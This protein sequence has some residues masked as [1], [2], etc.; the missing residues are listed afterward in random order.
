MSVLV[1][2]LDSDFHADAVVA[3][4]NEHGVPVVRI[5]PTETD[6]VPT[7]V[8]IECEEQPSRAWFRS[9]DG[10]LIDLAAITGVLCRFAVDTLI[11]GDSAAALRM[12]AEAEGIAAFTAALRTIPRTRWINDPWLEARANCRVV[13]ATAAHSHGLAVPPF[14]VSS[15]YEDLV[16]FADRHGACVIKALSDASLA[17]IGNRFVAPHELHTTDFLAPY[18]AP[19]VPLPTDATHSLDDT[20]SL[21]QVL[22]PKVEDVRVTVV[23]SDVF[24]AAMICQQDDPVDFRRNR[25]IDCQ[26]VDL[27]ATVATS[28]VKVVQSLGMRFAS[29]DLVVDRH[30]KYYFL[31]S[32]VS[33]NWLW[34]EHGA[35]LPISA[36]I[37]QALRQP[38]VVETA[39]STA[40]C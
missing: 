25:N 38:P 16:A 2:A 30:G 34:T 28:L 39:Q 29:C 11:P 40:V 1:L 5:D 37:A 17:R 22:I 8:R 12:F 9:P 20:P 24:A 13:Q 14:I 6:R 27:P 3:E 33:G 23:D 10:R 4:L 21:V 7:L 31:E 35:G 19:F 32:N 26:R 18:T 36:R 15:L